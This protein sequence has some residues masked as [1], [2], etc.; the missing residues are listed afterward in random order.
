MRVA[1]T[2]ASAGIGACLA[3]S[4]ARTGGELFLVARRED[5]LRSVSEQCLSSGASKAAFSS[6]DLSLAGQG[7]AL[8]R[9]AIDELG[10]LDVLVCNAG[11]GIYG[12]VH[13]VAPAAMARAMQ[14]N[15]L[16]GYESIHAALQHFVPR[17]R[18]HIVLVSSVL[19]KTP[20]PLAAPYC[21]TKFAQVG[22]GEALWGELRGS[23][24]GVSVI[25]PGY[26][27][28]EFHEAAVA[29]D[30][31]AAFK[32]VGGHSPQTVAEAI[33]QAIA[34]NKREVL[35]TLPGRFFAWMTR[36]APGATARMT[37]GFIARARRGSRSGNSAD[38]PSE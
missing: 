21:A 29:T 28:S 30:S 9:E 35:L 1:I 8:V 17:K 15:F 25:C 16:S 3:H 38:A 22:L 12:P 20:L 26:T 2:G 7:E 14:V 10:G 13:E 11:Y 31:A 4:F 27:K 37:A 5:R 18:G 24:V 36:M 33:V 6:R 34:K 19:G 23:G 32:R